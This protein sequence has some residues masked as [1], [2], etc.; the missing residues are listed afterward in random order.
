MQDLRLCSLPWWESVSVHM[1]MYTIYTSSAN[2]PIR[3][4]HR[5]NHF[6][7]TFPRT[8]ISR[9]GQSRWQ[10]FLVAGV[11]RAAEAGR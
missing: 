10:Q 2:I 5:C 11:P 6:A 1:E 9:A 4:F 3:F 7:A 8:G